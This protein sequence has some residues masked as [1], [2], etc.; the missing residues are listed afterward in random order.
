MKRNNSKPTKYFMLRRRK[1][2]KKC[3]NH[4]EKSRWTR[5]SRHH[6]FL[7]ICS[8]KIFF[9]FEFL[10]LS[11]YLKTFLL[12]SLFLDNSMNEM[13]IHRLFCTNS[14]LHFEFIDQYFSIF[15]FSVAGKVNS[16]VSNLSEIFL[17][18]YNSF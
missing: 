17:S 5:L 1:M 6:L 15:C 10:F 13:K 12:S 3:G 7:L 9:D 2:E 18:K 16:F 8:W 4:C 11:N 14:L